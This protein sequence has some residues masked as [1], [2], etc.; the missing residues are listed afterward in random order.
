MLLYSRDPSDYHVDIDTVKA[1]PHSYWLP[2]HGI[3]RG[4]IVIHDGDPT[5][6]NYPGI[7]KFLYNRFDY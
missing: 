7:G 4:S 5:T 3:Q 1:Y 2:G 6:H